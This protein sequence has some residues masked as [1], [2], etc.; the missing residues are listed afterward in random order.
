VWKLRSEDTTI[1]RDPLSN[2]IEIEIDP[3]VMVS[4][5]TRY[6]VINQLDK[7]ARRIIMH[8][9]NGNEKSVSRTYIIR[10]LVEYAVKHPDLIIEALRD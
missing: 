9:H 1:R 5:R 8:D 2:I 3:L 6:S 7:I 4:F 10:K